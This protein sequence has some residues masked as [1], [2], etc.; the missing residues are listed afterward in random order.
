MF[1]EM[2]ERTV[3]SWN[4]VITACVENFCIEDALGYFVKMKD[5]GFHHVQI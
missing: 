1:D 5:C 3:V 2:V 4:A